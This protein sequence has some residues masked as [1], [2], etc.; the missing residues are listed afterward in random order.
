MNLQR[1]KTEFNMS[2]QTRIYPV[3]FEEKYK[4]VFKY[5]IGQIVEYSIRD[6]NK[7]FGKGSKFG[8][9]TGMK[10]EIN[11]HNHGDNFV[12]GITY[13]INEEDIAETRIQTTYKAE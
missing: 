2:N 4:D 7:I 5:R 6:G 11:G 13:K 9:I 8:K 12:H 3:Y 1:A 10:L